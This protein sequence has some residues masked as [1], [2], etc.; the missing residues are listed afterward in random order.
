MRAIYRKP[1]AEDREEHCADRDRHGGHSLQI[2]AEGVYK[3]SNMIRV[4]GSRDILVRRLYPYNPNK[5]YPSQSVHY[6]LQA[7][8]FA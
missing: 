3:S 5:N 6:T 8:L 2:S 1:K 7:P 4:S